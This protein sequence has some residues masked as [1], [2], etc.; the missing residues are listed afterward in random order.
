MRKKNNSLVTEPLTVGR[1][2][3]ASMIGI[4][5]IP[6]TSGPHVGQLV[7]TQLAEIS[8]KVEEI[9]TEVVYK[10]EYNTYTGGFYFTQ[11]RVLKW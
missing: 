11:D 3:K 1:K 2:F 9:K 7:K 4:D 10:R 8:L 5:V 6:I